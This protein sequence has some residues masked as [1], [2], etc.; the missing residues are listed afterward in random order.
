V[1]PLATALAEV[2][3]G[4]L[5]ASLVL[6]LADV[7]LLD[8]EQAP[9]VTSAPAAR[10]AKCARLRRLRAPTR[11]ALDPNIFTGDLLEGQ[12]VAP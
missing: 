7:V 1:V 9:T 3:A 8:E 2:A 6:E 12:R 4:V 5:T 11:S 10:I